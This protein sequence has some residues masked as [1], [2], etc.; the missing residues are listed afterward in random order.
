MT[1]GPLHWELL[2]RARAV[3]QQ[4]WVALV[5]PA[6]DTNADYV[7]WG[8][9]TLINPW[10]T[11]VGELDEKPGTLISDIDLNTIAEMRAQIPIRKQKRTDLYE[12]ILKTN[13]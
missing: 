5:S 2:G 11:V 12:T 1:T 10:G 4:L 7:A 13:I 3:D 6:R 8:H 9:T